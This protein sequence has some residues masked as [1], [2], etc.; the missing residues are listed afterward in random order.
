MHIKYFRLT[1]SFFNDKSGTNFEMH[2]AWAKL[3]NGKYYLKD[4]LSDYEWSP[5]IPYNPEEDLEEVLEE[6]IFVECL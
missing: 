4:Y 2:T 5:F 1:Y 3:E 6:D